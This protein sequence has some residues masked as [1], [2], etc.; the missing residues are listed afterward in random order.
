MYFC[1][2]IHQPGWEVGHPI[3]EVGAVGKALFFGMEDEVLRLGVLV[4]CTSLGEAVHAVLMEGGWM[5]EASFLIVMDEAKAHGGYRCAELASGG[6]TTERACIEVIIVVGGYIHR[7][8]R[9]LGGWLGMFLNEI[10]QLGVQFVGDV[11]ALLFDVLVEDDL[12]KGGL[13]RE[14]DGEQCYPAWTCWQ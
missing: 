10:I 7:G 6:S 1:T 9:G 13:R 2:Y 4:D 3:R 11:G 8:D 5:T 12:V 14:G